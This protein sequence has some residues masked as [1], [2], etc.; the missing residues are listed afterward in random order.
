[1]S[2]VQMLGAKK[3]TAMEAL[4]QVR[5]ANKVRLYPY[6]FDAQPSM[7]PPTMTPHGL[8]VGQSGLPLAVEG[9]LVEVREEAAVAFL[10]GRVSEELRHEGCVVALHD[11]G[12]GDDERPEDG[13][14]V[15]L[16]GLLHRLLVLCA[17]G[18]L[19]LDPC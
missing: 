1:M 9:I 10:E 6:L 5:A 7:K 15:L 4:I 18:R 19:G 16:E 14:L 3:T 17:V 8:A 13:L 12:H 11:D 2:R